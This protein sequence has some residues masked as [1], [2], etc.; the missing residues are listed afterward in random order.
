MNNKIMRNRRTKK[1][2]DRIYAYSSMLIQTVV[3][4]ALMLSIPSASSA[5]IG[6]KE[7]EASPKFILEDLN[8]AP[9][10]VGGLFGRKPVIIA[11]WE[12]PISKSFIDY[13]MDVLKFLNDFYEQH[14]DATGLEVVGIYTPEDDGEVPGSEIERVKNLVKVN[15]IKF[16]ILVDRGFVIFREYGVIALPST[17]MIDKEGKIKFVYPSFPQAAQPVVSEQIRSLIGLAQAP[18]AKETEKKTGP[19]SHSVRLYNYALQMYEKGLPEQALSPLKKSVE[20]DADFPPAHNLMGIILWK[21][22]N[23]EGAIGEFEK[24][25]TLDKTYVPAHFNYGVLLFESEKSAEAERHFKETLSLNSDLAEAHYVLGLLYK[26]TDRE[27]EAVRELDTALV[28]FEK[29][30]TASAYEIYA[31]SAFHRISTLYTLSEL[32]RKKGEAARALDVL[33]KAAR[34]ALGLEIKNE[35]ENLHRSRDLMLYE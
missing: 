11:F 33:Q 5:L 26:K 35:K 25:V 22:G 17:V 20:M 30:K 7:G 32:Y 34:L 29:R 18:A 31:P 3:L 21:L 2:A 15:K 27:E 12:L 14:H 24:A 6:I 19:D 8:G 23:F 28:L 10:D 4:I 16:T 9:V 13:S 1:I